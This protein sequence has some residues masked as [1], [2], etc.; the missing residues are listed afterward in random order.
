MCTQELK[1][2]STEPFLVGTVLQILNSIL[3]HVHTCVEFIV[4]RSTNGVELVNRDLIFHI[5]RCS[6]RVTKAVHSV[7]WLVSD[8]AQNRMS[9]KYCTLSIFYID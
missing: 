3:L 6:R 7:Q 2:F 4:D 1:P 9:C 5:L 8:I